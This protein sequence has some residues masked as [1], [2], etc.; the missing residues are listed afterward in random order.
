MNQAKLLIKQLKNTLDSPYIFSPHSISFY[1]G[2]PNDQQLNAFR[3]TFLTVCAPR[4]Y[5]TSFSV[6]QKVSDMLLMLRDSTESLD[7]FLGVLS[8]ASKGIIEG[9]VCFDALQN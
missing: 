6:S 4:A 1:D 9:L 5:R 7:P 2:L 8:Q 3:L